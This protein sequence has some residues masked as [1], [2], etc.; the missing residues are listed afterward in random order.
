LI[1][2]RYTILILRKIDGEQSA[3]FLFFM[4]TVSYRAYTIIIQFKI[5]KDCPSH[6]NYSFGFS[7]ISPGFFPFGRIRLFSL[8]D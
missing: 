4:W 5:R 6:T 1:F 7:L 2:L 3:A 8:F